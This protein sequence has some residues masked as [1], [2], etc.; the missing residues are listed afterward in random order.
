MA[1]FVWVAGD[2]AAEGRDTGQCDVLLPTP[3]SQHDPQFGFTE[4]GELLAQLADLPHQCR[5]VPVAVVGAWGRR[6]W[7]S[8]LRGCRRLGALFPSDTAFCD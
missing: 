4:V 7:Q 6:I 5:G 2:D 3:W 8:G 1:H